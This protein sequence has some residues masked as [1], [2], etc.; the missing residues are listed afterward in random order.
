VTAS[1]LDAGGFFGDGRRMKSLVPIFAW[2]AL[3]LAPSLHAEEL[4]SVRGSTVVARALGNAQEGLKKD[5]DVT[6][7]FVAEVN[8]L[9]MI[10][11][12]ASDVFDVALF[13]RPMSGQENAL[14]PD[15]K[16]TETLIGKQAVLV[17]VPEQVWKSGVHALTRE[18]FRSIYEGETTNWK[19]LGGEDRDIVYYNREVGRGIWDLYMIYLYGAVNKAPISKA[20]TLTNATDVVTAVEF[21]VA[22]LS[23]LEYGEFQGT[24]LR[25]LGLKQDDGTVVDPTPENIANGKYALARPL[26]LITAKHPTGKLREFME[27]MTAPE[28]Q[29]AVKKAGHVPL[30]ELPLKKK[31]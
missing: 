13:T 15:R 3:V 10:D 23:L 12:L 2:V 6:L 17:V 30:A 8:G 21:N 1:L 20:E 26:N 11:K 14:R 5:H 22:A 31:E 29:A 24:R 18:Q 25:A 28:G 19:K 16:F 4:I 7:N 9:E 27:F